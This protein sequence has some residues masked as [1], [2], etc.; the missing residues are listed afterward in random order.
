MRT[1][2][3]AALSV[4]AGCIDFRQ[5][6]ACR[7]DS[8]CFDYEC[9]AGE[10]QAPEPGAGGGTGGGGGPPAGGGSGGGTGLVAIATSQ[11][12][13]AHLVQDTSNLFWT[14]RSA[15]K[16]VL[17]TVSKTGSGATQLADLGTTSS[18][19]E[20]ALAVSGNHIY[21][22][23]G[24]R[25]MR[26]P[27]AGGQLETLTTSMAGEYGGGVGVAS[28]TLVWLTSGDGATVWKRPVAG[29]AVETVATGENFADELITAQDRLYWTVR[30]GVVVFDLAT[31]VRS[32]FPSSLLHPRALSG[33]GTVVVWLEGQGGLFDEIA[34]T[35]VG[36][37]TSRTF[38]LDRDLMAVASDGATTVFATSRSTQSS[39]STDLITLNTTDGKG[40]SVRLTGGSGVTGGLAT[41]IVADQSFLFVIVD[42]QILRRAR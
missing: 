31:S 1:H 3:F 34:T 27:K 42:D 37:G 38:D 14:A 32:R 36:S 29:G 9:V 11:T 21:A 33:N 12:D 30:D 10:C 35:T 2:L 28:T 7:T 41:E 15:A 25:V 22:V 23:N 4:F 13:A 6:I 17:R 19:R 24:T 40:T 8:D 20:P 16:L 39:S 26:V 5:G 18:A